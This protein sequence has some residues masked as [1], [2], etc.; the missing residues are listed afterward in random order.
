MSEVNFRIAY[1]GDALRD[2]TMDVRELAPALLSLGQVFE[3]ANRV[4]N[5]NQ[6]TVNLRVRALHTGSFEIDFAIHQ[7]IISQFIEFFAGDGVTAAVNLKEFVLGGGIIG[8]GV[9][10]LIKLLK[11]KRPR[12]IRDDEDGN[13]EIEVDGTVIT[14]PKKLLALI[15]DLAVRQAIEKVLKPL[16]TNKGIDTF[17]VREDGRVIEAVNKKDVFYFRVPEAVDEVVVED[18]RTAA[19]SIVSLAF[20]D[21]NKW[22]LSDGNGTISARICDQDFLADV[23]N[24]AVAFAKGDILLC[25]VKIKQ[26][27]TSAGLKTE[28][29]VVKVKEHRP[30]ARQLRLF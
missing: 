6:T 14:V 3:E 16:E 10:K 29:E 25:E 11:G 27:Q 28:Y 12:K 19:F 13:T 2:G 23:D 17:E 26:I 4:L 7:S 15:T 24:N 22:R 18:I 21:E 5:G 9:F 20:K 1:D 8:V 30:A